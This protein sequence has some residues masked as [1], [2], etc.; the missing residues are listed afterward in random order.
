M[1]IFKRVKDIERYLLKIKE[2]GQKVNF[3]PT[4]GALHNGHLSLVHN[5]QNEDSIVVVSIFVNPT[6]FN[7]KKDFEKYPISIDQDTSML[8]KGGCDVL[9][10]PSVD[11]MYP[12]GVDKMPIYSFDYL[13]KILEGEK[14]PGHFEGVGQVVARLLAIVQPNKLYMG[15]KD[16]QQCMVVKKLLSLINSK[17]ELHICA[18]QREEDGLAMSS[19]NKRLTEFQRAKAMLLYQCLVSIKTKQGMAP[20]STV[21]KECIDILKEKG[22]K[23]EYVCL[24]DAEDLT[25]LEDYDAGRNMVAL[26]VA[27]LGDVRLID[28]MLLG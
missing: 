6:Q 11:E 28:N 15:Q 20:F 9:F 23:P 4:M 3:V 17:A 16:Y 10:L 25:I 22:F 1:V 7:D 2:K 24:A 18:T 14:R 5:A 27:W 26:I 13:D 21:Q 12:E 19:R 8:L